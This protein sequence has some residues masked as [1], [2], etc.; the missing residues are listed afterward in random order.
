MK[1]PFISQTIFDNRETENF[2]ARF[3]AF[4]LK[5]SSTTKFSP[6]ETLSNFNSHTLSDLDRN[7]CE[8]NLHQW[9]QCQTSHK[10]MRNGEKLTSLH[11]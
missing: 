8:I 1:D 6:Y 2:S 3:T 5:K 9:D 10:S 7:R 4:E 11:P